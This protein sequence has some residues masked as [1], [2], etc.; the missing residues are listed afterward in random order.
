MAA[1]FKQAT[2]NAA[3]VASSLTDYPAFVDLSRIGITTQA[4]A[5][6]VRVYSDA[7]KTTELAR[8]IVSATEMHVK[9]PSLTTTTVIYVDY[10]GS[11]ADY[12]VTDTYGRNAVWSDYKIVVHLNESSGTRTD[13][14]G[15]DN[16]NDVNTVPSATGKVGANGANFTRANSERLDTTTA[17][18]SS[19]DVPLEME[20]WHK[21]SLTGTYRVISSLV[22]TGSGGGRWFFEIQL[23]S[24]NYMDTEMGFV[25]GGN[26][27]VWYVADTSTVTDG[28]WHH[29]VAKVRNTGG[30]AQIK[31]YRDGVLLATVNHASLTYSLPATMQ[32]FTVG[33]TKNYTATTYTHYSTGDIDESRLRAGTVTTDEYTTTSYNNQSDEATFWGTWT[34]VSTFTP[35]AMWFM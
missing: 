32:A 13:S 16:L 17:N 1:G 12:S 9:I 11:R 33:A 24:D 28:N 27:G 20:L 35:Q 26:Q 2:V 19:G 21:T 34:N 29:W 23:G 3:K 10:D 14:C 25:N 5:D 30:K 7:S 31:L 15:N 4:E 6:S 8:E 22:V 18:V